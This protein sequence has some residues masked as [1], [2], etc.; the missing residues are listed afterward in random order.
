MRI[1]KR[2][3]DDYFIV[4]GDPIFS[5]PLKRAVRLTEKGSPFRPIKLERKSMGMYVFQE[6]SNGFMMI[7]GSKL[8]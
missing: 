6:A 7:A 8:Y 5:K 2:D 1:R 4:I 3:S